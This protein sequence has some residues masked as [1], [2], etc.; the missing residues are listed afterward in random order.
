[1]HPSGDELADGIGQI[2]AG[3]EPVFRSCMRAFCPMRSRPLTD[4]ITIDAEPAGDR[5]T[6]EKCSRAV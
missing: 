3:W 1:M 2:A 6:E 5:E 4:S